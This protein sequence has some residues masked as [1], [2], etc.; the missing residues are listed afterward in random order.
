MFPVAQ[1][2]VM[3]HSPHDI[4]STVRDTKASAICV[5]TRLGLQFS[6]ESCVDSANKNTILV[7][8]A[9]SQVAT[10]QLSFKDQGVMSFSSDAARESLEHG[11]ARTRTHYAAK[12]HYTLATFD[13]L[14]H[15]IASFAGITAT[16]LSFEAR[17]KI[18]YRT[19]S[20]ESATILFSP[21][22][23]RS[24]EKPFAFP[25][26]KA[27][28][29]QEGRAY[30]KILANVRAALSQGQCN[31]DVSLRIVYNTAMRSLCVP[32]REDSEMFSQAS[33]LIRLLQERLGLREKLRPEIGL[34]T[35]ELGQPGSGTATMNQEI[36]TFMPSRLH[37]FVGD[38]K[39]SLLVD[40]CPI[41]ACGKPLM[42]GITNDSMCESGH[43]L[44]V[45][46]GITSLP[47]SDPKLLKYCEDCFRPFVNELVYVESMGK[48]AVGNIL[49]YLLSTFKACP[50]CTGKFYTK[51]REV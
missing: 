19:L 43:A 39:L 21:E 44:S 37:R 23:S 8:T 48:H 50:F 7:G 25:W 49:P 31:G 6:T 42:L 45:R 1:M 29:V 38:E 12:H 20:E 17:H 35:H 51:H 36:D 24:I 10:L 22:N 11:L 9:E 2:K 30:G 27:A 32:D 18:V 41:S 15:G 46:C 13:A 40:R 47:I 26:Q 34:L 14:M 5:L 28:E 4:A 3:R 33:S 16:C